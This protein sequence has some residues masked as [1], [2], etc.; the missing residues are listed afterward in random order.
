MRRTFLILASAYVLLLSAAF[1]WQLCADLAGHPANPRY[2]L[3]FQRA[4]GSIF[5]RQ[6]RALAFSTESGVAC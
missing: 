3:T 2:Y 4:R 1:Y 6:G 5:D